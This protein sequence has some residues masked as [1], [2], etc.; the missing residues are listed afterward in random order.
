M[1]AIQISITL[2]SQAGKRVL[3]NEGDSPITFGRD[4]GN[5]LILDDTRVSREHGQLIFDEGQWWVENQSPNGL[6][7]G[8][9]NASK[10]PAKLRSGDVVKAGDLSLFEISFKEMARATGSA[11]AEQEDFEDS[12]ED[13]PKAGAKKRSNL[14]L[15]VIIYLVVIAI[16][17][18]VISQVR[19][20]RPSDENSIVRTQLSPTDIENLIRQPL[21]ESQ[22]QPFDR[23]RG[24]QALERAMQLY[25]GLELSDQ[26]LFPAYAAFRE[27]MAFY[28]IP[29]F[30]DFENPAHRTAYLDVEQR[31]I[32][33]LT[34]MYRIGMD[35]FQV[36][37]YPAAERQF[38]QIVELFADDQSDLFRNAQHFREAALRR[39]G[40][41]R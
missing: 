28:R 7:V 34:R 13:R 5:R 39:S 31:L 30:V 32:E 25:R 29:T 17:F 10:K 12:D 36:S 35:A 9:R 14:W 11:E 41:R 3:L 8:W 40:R 20:S 24:D 18:V 6:R 22:M 23:A 4:A 21:P 15:G 2:G 26:N 38:S 37:D 1:P 27:A 16:V 19:D 33:R